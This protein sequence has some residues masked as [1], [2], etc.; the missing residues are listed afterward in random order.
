MRKDALAGAV[1]FLAMLSS[2]GYAQMTEQSGTA[3]KTP[4][5]QVTGTGS[6]RAKPDLATIGVGVATE[7]VN[8]QNA[9]ARN[10]A[11]TV[12]VISELEAAGVEKKDLQTANFSV[13][14]NYRNDSSGRPQSVTFRASN[15]I[16]VTIRDLGKAGEILNRVVAAGS[17]Q[18]N[19]PMFSVSEPEKYLNEARKKAV[20]NAMEK[21]AAYA[22]AAGLKLGA[23]LSIAEGSA[24]AQVYNHRGAV[25]AAA[26]AAPPPPVEAGEETIGASVSLAIELKP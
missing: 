23:V 6:V 16:N 17:N 21:A 11:A 10:S 20:E 12:K 22:G 2:T 9:V 26:S 25:F 18:I 19:G 3:P 13:Y 1:A 14:P 5:I 7:D 8:A 4:T 15:T 24:P